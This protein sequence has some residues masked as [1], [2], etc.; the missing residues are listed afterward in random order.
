MLYIV[1]L[2]YLAVVY[3]RPTEILGGWRDVPVVWLA[4]AATLPLFALKAI[5][6]K[7]IELPQDRL[8]LAYWVAIAISNLVLGWFGGV[9]QG[10]LRFGQIVYQYFLVRAAADT[11]RRLRGVI[12]LLTLMMLFHAVSGL[13]QHQTGLGFGDIT[14]IY[15]GGAVRIRSA[16]IFNDPNDLGLAIVM[17]I[18]F[19]VL[20]I[21]NRE[22]SGRLVAAALAALAVMLT[23]LYLTNSRGAM[24]GLGAMIVVY[25]WSR[26]RRIA[27]AA[28]VVVALSGLVIA[29]PSRVDDFDSS[30]AS[31]QGR[32]QAWSEAIQMLKERPLT[33]VGWSLFTEHHELVAHNSFIHAFA[34]LGLFGGVCLVGM[35]YWYFAG[36]RRLPVDRKNMDATRWRNALL[37]AGA[38]V[39]VAAIFLSRQYDV[40]PY[41]LLA[42]GATHVSLERQKVPLE[43]GGRDI[44]AVALLSVATVLATYVAVRL[45]AVWSGG[46]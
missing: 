40:V 12:V 20:A 27:A 19:L 7:V 10:G 29:G 44:A 25:S 21:A 1:T 42:V 30:E 22:A 41:T 37:S 34:E 5:N 15:S 2:V 9:L 11:P 45:L 36:L 35:V 31:A 8:L 16:G 4:T 28:V 26:F 23:A 32:I 24:L 6:R 38:G 33:G 46:W 13:I 17:V 18:P 14:P 39:F 43:T 3:L